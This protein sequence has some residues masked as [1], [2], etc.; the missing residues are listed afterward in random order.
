MS[1]ELLPCPFC[2]AGE[3]KI[4]ETQYWT[5]LQSIVIAARVHHWCVRGAGQPGSRMEIAGKTREDAIANWN[6]RA[7][8]AQPVPAAVRAQ[9][10]SYDALLI[11]ARSV[12][13]ALLRA[14]VEE[15][16]DPGEAI[17]VLRERYERRISA[18]AESV[19]LAV[20]APSLIENKNL[21]SH[22]CISNGFNDNGEAICFWP[23]CGCSPAPSHAVP[24]APSERNEAGRGEVE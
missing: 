8:P 7:A 15:C 6:G 22:P 23:N 12:Q 17:D 19:P 24:A 10:P 18:L 16:D 3:T 5:G 14:G 4:H 11:I 20:L 1:D 21:S 13:G 2:G 9:V